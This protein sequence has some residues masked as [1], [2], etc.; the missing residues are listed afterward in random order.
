VNSNVNVVAGKLFLQPFRTVGFFRSFMSCYNF[1]FEPFFLLNP[2][3][4]ARRSSHWL[5]PPEPYIAEES[6][7]SVETA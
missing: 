7:T 4:S 6:D 5:K 3:V 2:V 1:E